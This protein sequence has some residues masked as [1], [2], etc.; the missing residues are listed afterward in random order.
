MSEREELVKLTVQQIEGIRARQEL[1][2]P[3]ESAT[4]YALCDFAIAALSAQ[5]Q[6]EPVAWMQTVENPGEP[7]RFLLSMECENSL[8]RQIKHG[9]TYQRKPLY[10]A[11]PSGVREGMLRAAEICKRPKPECCGRFERDDNALNEVCCG[12][13]EPGEYMDGVECADAITRA[14]D[15][16]D[17]E[18]THV[19]VPVDKLTIS[20]CYRFGID[21]SSIRSTATATGKEG[22]GLKR[23]IV[24]AANLAPDGTVTLQ[25]RHCAPPDHRQGFIDN[26]GNWLTREQAYLVAKEAG[27]IIRRVGG[28]DG[29][30]FS[31]NIY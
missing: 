23:R 9:G 11:P 17:A 22:G 14:A 18:Q 24:C 27:Q 16:V 15:Q 3:Q 10:T 20:D 1:N 21:I 13:L 5:P 28:D 29:K 2:I 12:R 31:E 4:I 8:H 19:R 6:Q 30:L 7:K 26:Q 25:V